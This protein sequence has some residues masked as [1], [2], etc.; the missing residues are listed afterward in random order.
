[1]VALAPDALH[2]EPSPKKLNIDWALV[3]CVFGAVLCASVGVAAATVEYLDRY[4]TRPNQYL[5][6]YVGFALGLALPIIA[7]WQ[8]AIADGQLPA[9]RGLDPQYE[10]VSGWSAILLVV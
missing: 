8:R 3:A 5:I 1:M 4:L 7:C 10:H 9:K 6:E 2:S